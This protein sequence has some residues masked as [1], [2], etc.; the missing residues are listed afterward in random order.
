MKRTRRGYSPIGD[1]GV[2]D[3]NVWLTRAVKTIV[4]VALLSVTAWA[5]VRADRNGAFSGSTSISSVSSGSNSAGAITVP[6]VSLSD[7]ELLHEWNH[8]EDGEWS[9]S[10]ST[11][12]TTPARDGGLSA[13]VTNEYSSRVTHKMFPYP[14]LEDGVLVEPYKPTKIT[15]NGIN[16]NTFYWSII[17]VK[18]PS[19]SFHGEAEECLDFTVTLTVVGEYTLTVEESYD[20]FRDEFRMRTLKQSLWVKYVRREISTLTDVDREEFLDAFRVLWDIQTKKGKEKY[21]E[22]Y[23]SVNYLAMT[24]NDGSGNYF[25]DEFESGTAFLNNHAYLRLYLEQSLRLVNPR[26]SLH[27]MDYSKYF[28]TSEFS[29]NHMG[30]PMDGG[31]WTEILSDKWFGKNDPWTGQILDSR[32]KDTT[33]PA[34]TS[35]LLS[36]ESVPLMAYLFIYDDFKKS[37]QHISNPYGLLRAPWNYNPSGYLARFN[38]LNGLATSTLDMP[39]KFSRYAGSTC[40]SMKSFFE[41]YVVGKTLTNFLEAVEEQVH[42]SIRYTFGGAGGDRA[43]AA[44]AAL[45]NDFKLTDEQLFYVAEAA[46][47]FA[48]TYLSGRFIAFSNNPLNCTAT[49]MSVRESGALESKAVPGAVGGPLCQCNSYYLATEDK[50]GAPPSP[51]PPHRS[52]PPHPPTPH[53]SPLTAP[54]PSS[55][56]W[57]S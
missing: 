35:K 32:W 15:I 24:Y 36:E 56:R 3:E 54:P 40:A 37:D 57:T 18:D 38:N 2:D 26:V 51:R 41:L 21:G 4:A 23:K 43:A 49:P 45:K 48:E 5:F 11:T 9:T 33:V 31:A 7:N 6:A 25:C 20:L 14:F 47:D 30:D 27:Y 29:S 22:A 17:N 50:V 28:E 52:P 46:H 1:D 8:Q 53:R 55:S 12:S 44:D 19:I 42:D 39:T 10:E 13:V 16:G 34:V